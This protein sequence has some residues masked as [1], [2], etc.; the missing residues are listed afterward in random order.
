MR[1]AK[2]FLCYSQEND[3]SEYRFE[4]IQQLKQQLEQSRDFRLFL[5]SPIIDSRTKEKIIPQLLK[6]ASQSSLNFVR[7]MIRQHREAYLYDTTK[8]FIRL[9]KKTL[10]LRVAHVTTVVPLNDALRQRLRAEVQ[11]LDPGTQLEERV[12]PSLIGGFIIRV[13]D[14][15]FDQSIARKLSALRK[16]LAQNA[17]L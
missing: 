17:Y 1:Y 7:L 9:Y 4:E 13:G 8:A 10:G 3:T 14:Q 16:E 2:G 12:D 6:G 11:I 15:Q 5:K